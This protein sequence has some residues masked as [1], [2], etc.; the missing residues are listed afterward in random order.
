MGGVGA[1][2]FSSGKFTILG[3]G[4]DVWGT[5]YEFHYV[6]QPLNGDGSITVRVASME[7]P[8]ASDYSRA[9]IMTRETT[10]VG[11]KYASMMLHP[12]FGGVRLQSRSSTNGNTAELTL[13]D[14]WF[15]RARLW[16]TK[17]A[18]EV[19]FP[20]WRVHDVRSTHS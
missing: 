9:G 1:S 6:S 14:D 4:A 15:D 16:Y 11:S 18:R 12:G 17:R 5:S 10:A 19:G 3:G 7:N 8:A 2:G 20:S 13:P